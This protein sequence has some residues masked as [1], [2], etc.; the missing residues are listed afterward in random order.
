MHSSGGEGKQGIGFWAGLLLGAWA[1]VGGGVG[2][3]CPIT[4]QMQQLHHK[5]CPEV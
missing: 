5:A 1:R 2:G 3:R 4:W